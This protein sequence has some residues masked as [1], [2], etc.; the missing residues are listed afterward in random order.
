MAYMYAKVSYG[1][2]G[3]NYGDSPPSRFSQLDQL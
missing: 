2:E 1:Y 3:L